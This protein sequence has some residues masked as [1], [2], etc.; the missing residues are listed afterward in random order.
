MGEGGVAL[1]AEVQQGALKKT[2]LI[3]QT[4]RKLIKSF[5]TCRLTSRRQATCARQKCS[6]FSMPG[7]DQP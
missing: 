4:E 5:H 1:A 3:S 7:T 6:P 2:R